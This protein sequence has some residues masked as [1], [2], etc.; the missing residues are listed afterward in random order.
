MKYDELYKEYRQLLEL[1]NVPASDRDQDTYWK[2]HEEFKKTLRTALRDDK[3]LLAMGSR[4]LIQ[5][6]AWCSSFRP[7]EPHVIL[8]TFSLLAKV[9]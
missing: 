9:N 4:E 5:F 3:L 8:S 2:A 1:A 7:R 6:L